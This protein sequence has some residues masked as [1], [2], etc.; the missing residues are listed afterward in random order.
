VQFAAK[1]KADHV[2]LRSNRN[3][4]CCSVGSCKERSFQYSCP[5]KLLS[6]S[7]KRNYFYP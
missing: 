1:P 5:Q 2:R 3:R 7:W 4:T 6:S